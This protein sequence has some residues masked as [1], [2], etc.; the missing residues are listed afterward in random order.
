[1]N[2][3]GTRVGEARERDSQDPNSPLKIDKG[4]ALEIRVIEV[5]IARSVRGGRTSP[6]RR[7]QVEVGGAE[8]PQQSRPL[9]LFADACT[10]RRHDRVFRIDLDGF[11]P[12]Q[13]FAPD[14]SCAV[15]KT[16]DVLGR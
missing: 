2:F 7:R 14:D 3:Q 11:R 12:V 16:E 4:K 13:N 9:T 6:G 15:K 8:F 5:G 10:E 1:M